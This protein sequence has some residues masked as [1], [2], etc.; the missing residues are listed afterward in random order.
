M[1]RVRSDSAQKVADAHHLVCWSI[2]PPYLSRACRLPINTG[3]IGERMDAQLPYID[4]GYVDE[5]ADV[6]GAL[7]KLLGGKGAKGSE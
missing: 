4:S 7:G 5:K 1:T 6:M 3:L 2:A